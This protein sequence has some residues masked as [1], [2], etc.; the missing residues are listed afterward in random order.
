M[1]PRPDEHDDVVALITRQ[2]Q[3][4]EGNI[5]YLG[6]AE[7]GIRAELA[8]LQPA[9][10]ET[11]RVARDVAGTIAGAALVERDDELGRAWIFG[12]WIDGDDEAWARW[13]RGLV[14]EVMAELPDGIVDREMCGDVA[15]VRLAALAGELGWPASETNYAYVVD[16]ATAAGWGP[17]DRARIRPAVA[18]DEVAIQPLHDTEFPATYATAAH[19]VEHAG[20]GERIVLVAED[21]GRFA[22]YAAG[23]VQPDGSGYIDFIAVAPDGR[24]GGT[25]RRLVTALAR[26]LLGEH[27]GRRPHGAG[28]P[29]PARALYDALGFRVDAAFRGYR[30][31]P[32]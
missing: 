9:W 10:T 31:R 28:A 13:A 6:V 26:E 25:G 3:R 21:E 2:Q 5:V 30:T 19:L 32:D 12:P 29:R 27:A 7:E 23:K 1:Q 24:R 14:D 18:G 20:R 15:N 8:D 17:D 22:G 11:V 16:R 4:P